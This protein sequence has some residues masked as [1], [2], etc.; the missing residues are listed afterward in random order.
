MKLRRHF[1]L[2]I[3]SLILTVFT[4][5]CGDIE[6]FSTGGTPTPTPTITGPDSL[7]S[8]QWHLINTGQSSFSSGIAISG[9]DINYQT[10]VSDGY[11]GNGIYILL[12][13]DG[14][15]SSH[16][17]LSANF[18]S[19]RS[20]DYTQSA[21]YT[22][23]GAHKSAGDI[24]G[25]PVAGIMAA[26]GFNNTGVRGI[27]HKAKIASANLTS[28]SVIQTTAKFVDQA[29]TTADIVNQSWGSTQDLIYNINATYLAQLQSATTSG[30]SSKGTIFV[31][32]AGNDYSLDIGSSIYRTGNSNFD[33]YKSTPYGIV[34]AALD[35]SDVATSRS[36][37][38]SNLWISAYGGGDGDT[39][40]AIV[41]TDRSGCTEG[42]S[43]S[44]SIINLFENGTDSKNSS[45]NYTS[46]MNGTSAAAPM[47]SG[48]IALILEANSS[49]TWRD[50]KHI[51]A[52]SA[53][54][55][56][57]AIGNIENPNIASPAGH[58]WEQGWITNSA[59]Y[60]FHN[61]FGFGKINTDAAVALAKTYSTNLGTFSTN[62]TDSGTIAV[63]I[64]DNSSV[65]NT[66][67]ITVATSKTI[68][69]IQLSV[70]VTHA[71]AGDIGIELTSPSGTK[72]ILKNV[73]D[74][75]SGI[76]NLSSAIF[77]SNAFYGENSAGIWTL[78]VLDGAV[79]STGTL[80]NWK[81]SIYGN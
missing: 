80:T 32:S 59:G 67:T 60:K 31:Q 63:A 39:S 25:T 41:T 78:K 64:T 21:P 26:A 13:D 68:E 72:S 22:G 19:T 56:N 5:S 1:S 40:P 9:K 53:T 73:N 66:S 37:P 11:T 38:G 20:R 16:E 34:V 8:E 35:A 75:L 18:D 79:G 46:T 12:S 47:I 17:D 3:T 14:I 69:A 50:I 54:Q 29:N 70:S 28:L 10:T 52:S 30:R 65:G 71:N 44:F 36:S 49:L 27:S 62:Q 24:H 2:Q 81:L 7:F 76:S 51:L 57:A 74:S 58:T 42:L 15:D 61:R 33:G 45:C 6:E 23:I 77:L 55:V 4:I 48:V 43:T